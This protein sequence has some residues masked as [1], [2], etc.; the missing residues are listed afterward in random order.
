[1]DNEIKAEEELARLQTLHETVER[2]REQL[3]H[4]QMEHPSAESTTPLAPPARDVGTGRPDSE[5]HL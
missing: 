2:L 3:K 4:I 1:M 5:S